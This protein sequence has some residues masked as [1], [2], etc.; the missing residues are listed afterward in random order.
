M[1]R[2]GSPHRAP[3]IYDIWRGGE[4]TEEWIRK[5]GR[6]TTRR[7]VRVA[8]FIDKEDLWRRI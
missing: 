1:D 2:S 4:H 8:K 6:A 3:M 7:H 5:S